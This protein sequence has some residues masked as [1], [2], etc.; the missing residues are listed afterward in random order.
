MLRIV[1]QIPVCWGL[2]PRALIPTLHGDLLK[3][4]ETGV[5]QHPCV[6]DPVTLAPHR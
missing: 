5:F 3:N 2:A 6:M 4:S 1:D